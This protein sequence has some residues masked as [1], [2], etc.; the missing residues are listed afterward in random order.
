MLL[1]EACP[2][3]AEGLVLDRGHVLLLLGD[4]AVHAVERDAS[5]VTD[6]AST[7]VGVGQA[8]HQVRTAGRANP[9]GV[10]VEDRFVVCLAVLGED[11]L[12]AKVGLEAGFLDRG[13]DHAP[14]TR[15]HHGTLQGHVGLQAD[16]DVIVGA[17][18]T[19][20]ESVHVAGDVGLD[21]VDALGA[22]DGEVVPLQ[23]RP[24]IEGLLG[25]ALEE[26]RVTFVGGEVPDD[27]V[28]DVDLVDPRAG[29]EP[30]PGIL[31]GQ[32][33]PDVCLGGHFAPMV[34]VAGGVTAG[35]LSATY[36][37]A[38]HDLV[39]AEF[40]PFMPARPWGGPNAGRLPQSRTRV[41][42][43]RRTGSPCFRSRVR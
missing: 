13:L 24:H 31:A 30:L 42:P 29:R 19:G 27:E 43:L 32:R 36:Q 18:V 35:N 10:H 21:V 12:H 6:D 11:L 23:R 15:R 8:G 40:Y 34:D 9:S 17:D 7:T 2:L 14:T 1:A 16:D 37:L 33:G 4:Q 26:R 25:C 38:V 3:L 20:G 28:P 5:V 39:T 41:A 22:L